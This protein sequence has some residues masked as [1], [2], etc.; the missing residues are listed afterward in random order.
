MPDSDSPPIPPEAGAGEGALSPDEEERAWQRAIE[1]MLSGEGLEAL[2]L[3]KK[4]A[5][6]PAAGEVLPFQPK[7][8]P[9][10][11][12]TMRKTMEQLNSPAAGPSGARG[13][14]GGPPDLAALLAQLGAD[15]SA[16]DGLGGED[17]D[18]L[19]GMLDGM[20]AQLMT[21]EVLEEPMSELASKVSTHSPFSLDG[22]FFK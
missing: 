18:E 11:D 4:G 15:P 8:R 21:R 6:P 14:G 5:K 17:D 10:F 12:E 9:D 22:V 1:M 3:D 19:G 16:L 20:M 7:S 2:G 13:G